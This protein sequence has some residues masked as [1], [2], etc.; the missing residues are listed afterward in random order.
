MFFFFVRGHSVNGG[1]V[2][3]RVRAVKDERGHTE[4]ARA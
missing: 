4:R 3:L 1:V 2:T